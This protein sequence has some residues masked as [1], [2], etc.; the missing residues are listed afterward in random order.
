[1]KF[2]AALDAH[3]KSNFVD[4]EKVIRRA[5]SRSPWTQ[6][7]SLDE[8]LSVLVCIISYFTAFRHANCLDHCKAG[9]GIRGNRR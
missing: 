5:D 2:K 1:V 7:D 4:I 9:M 6:Q 8:D 3:I